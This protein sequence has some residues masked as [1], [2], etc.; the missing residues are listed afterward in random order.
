MSHAVILFRGSSGTSTGRRGRS[1]VV[2]DVD[3]DGVV[4]GRS[5]VVGDVDPYGIL[6]AARKSARSGAR[7]CG[8]LLKRF[9]D[10]LEGGFFKA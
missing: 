10:A 2:E 5:R 6:G 4:S 8:V 7:K 9:A 3:P 1:R